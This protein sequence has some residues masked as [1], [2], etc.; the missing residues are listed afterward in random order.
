MLCD[1]IT[2]PPTSN[3]HIS[4][5][6]QIDELFHTDPIKCKNDV[7]R[8]MI[9][10]S[11]AINPDP[12]ES[13]EDLKMLPSSV[14]RST[15]LTSIALQPINVTLLTFASVTYWNVM[16]APS[17]QDKLISSSVFSLISTAMIEKNNTF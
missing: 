9:E 10:L 13:S 11:I 5:Y 12:G 15:F 6:L 8:M 7:L 2:A 14:N 3:G 4:A 1:P 16:L 17:A